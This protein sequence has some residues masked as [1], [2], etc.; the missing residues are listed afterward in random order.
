MVREKVGEVFHFFSK[1]S[2]AAIRL[3]DG[4]I[5]IGDTVQV[6]GPTTNLEQRVDGL[7]IEHMEVSRA[8]QGQDVGMKV[9]DRVRERD[10][11]YK[12]VEE[13]PAMMPPE[14]PAMPPARVAERAPTAKPPAPMRTSP[15]KPRAKPKKPV[16]RP[17][18]KRKKAA[19]KPRRA[20]KARKASR[21]A[22]KT[23]R[24]GSRGSRRRTR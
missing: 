20:K 7:Q 23:A 15:A 6:L 10:Y 9:R 22:R 1:I 13:P 18:K 19:R 11:V 12:I 2:V 3:T 24:R 17:T 5:A 8:D 16:K 21:G 14:A 4:S